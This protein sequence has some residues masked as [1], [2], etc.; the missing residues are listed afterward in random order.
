MYLASLLKNLHMSDSAVMPLC[1]VIKKKV[2]YNHGRCPIV[3]IYGLYCIKP[4]DYTCM[5]IE[6]TVKWYFK[7]W[8]HVDLLYLRKGDSKLL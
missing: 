3:I 1:K 8:N 5:P 7:F 4:I 2:L 6:E